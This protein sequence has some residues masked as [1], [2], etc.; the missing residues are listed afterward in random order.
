MPHLMK[1]SPLI[2]INLSVN[3][4]EISYTS[5]LF[6]AAVFQ[7]LAR[8]FDGVVEFL[9]QHGLRWQFGEVLGDVDTAGVEFQQFDLLL[10]FA[11]AG[12]DAQRRGFAGLLFVFGQPA[13]VELHLAF[14]F[15]FEITQFQFNHHQPFEAAVVDNGFGY[16]V[17]RSF[18]E[19]E[20]LILSYLKNGEY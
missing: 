16:A 18:E 2:S 6:P 3:N 11:A 9:L 5:V 14:V 13:Q 10:L 17:P 20:K 12:D 4:S 19:F 15:G 1:Y 7:P 8:P